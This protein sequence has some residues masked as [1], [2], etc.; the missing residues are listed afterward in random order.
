MWDG[1]QSETLDSPPQESRHSGSPG[2]RRPLWTAI[3]AQDSQMV[4]STQILYA[5][6]LFPSIFNLLIISTPSLI[7]KNQ[8]S[9]ASLGRPWIVTLIHGSEHPLS[10]KAVMKVTMMVMTAM[11]NIYWALPMCWD[12]IFASVI[13]FN[14]PNTLPLSTLFFCK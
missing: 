3:S 8:L 14:P 12:C 9:S 2:F 7:F 10:Y 1:V 11:T 4:I 5:F 13:S 6:P